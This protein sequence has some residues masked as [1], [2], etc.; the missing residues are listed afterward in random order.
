MSKCRRYGHM[1]RSALLENVRD[2]DFAAVRDV[3]SEPRVADQCCPQR[4]ALRLSSA[5]GVNMGDSL[6]TPREGARRARDH[7]M[8][9]NSQHCISSVLAVG[10]VRMLWGHTTCVVLELQKVSPTT[11]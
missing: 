9:R 1:Q 3:R 6:F 8:A 4:W 7:N 2:K 5:E 11:Q 10:R